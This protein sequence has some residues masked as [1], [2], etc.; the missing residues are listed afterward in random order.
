[1]ASLSDAT[2]ILETGVVSSQAVRRT[3]PQSWS[4]SALK[5]VETCPLRFVLSR[6][7]YPDLWDQRG[8]PRVPA[9]VKGDVV[10]G[11]LE[12]IVRALVKTGCPSTS[13]VQAVAVLRELGGYTAV[14]EQVLDQQ[15]AR[16]SDNPRIDASQRER[17]ARML[18][19]WLRQGREQIQTYLNRMELSTSG[20]SEPHA[21]S[22]TPKPSI[23]RSA[24]GLGDHSEQKL[25]ADELR[26]GGRVD[27]LSL[28]PAGV[29][30]IDFKTGAEDSSHHDQ[31][32][33][34]ALLWAFDRVVNP[35]SRPV[36]ALVAAY[37]TREVEVQVPSRDELAQLAL[38]T[39]DRVA[40]AEDAATAV[41][42]TAVVGEHCKLCSVR[43]LCA[44]YWATSPATASVGDGV[45][46][47]LGGTVVRQHG[48]KSWVLRENSTEAEVLL[49]TTAPSV[50]LPVGETIRILGAR[51]VVDPDEDDALIASLTNSSEIQMLTAAED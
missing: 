4:Y 45:W 15:L 19:D 3:V 18:T 47:D 30:L 21:E 35:E 22:D 24:I 48:V 43:A 28:K 49:R 16:Y 6:A 7:D 23:H 14:A 2:H 31:L 20:R 1:M 11:A 25:V 8:Y 32:R 38:D 10:H 40:S 27:L 37:P 44:T 12:I 33:L 51:R 36:R 13:S 50:T 17:L 42:P 41:K 46:Y 9:A 26:L 39:T 34:Y 29:T 5:E